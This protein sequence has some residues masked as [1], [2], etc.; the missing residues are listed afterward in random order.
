MRRLLKVDLATKINGILLGVISLL[1]ISLSSFYLYHYSQEYF[2]NAKGITLQSAKT[3]SYLPGIVSENALEDK[4]QLSIVMDQY[5]FDTDIDFIII[6]DIDGE[7]LYHP[8]SEEIGKIYDIKEESKA[9]IFGAYYVKENNIDI[10]ERAFI[11]YAPIYSGE[12]VREVVGVVKVGYYKSKIISEIYEKIIQLLIITFVFILISIFISR[13]FANYIKSE[14]LGYEPNEITNI[15]KNREN[16]FSALNEGIIS[17]DL[18]GKI[19][20]SNRAAKYFFDLPDID[21]IVYIDEFLNTDI[22]QNLES[23]KTTKKAEYLQATFKEKEFIVIIN[24]LYDRNE[25]NGYV[26]IIR[27]MTEK[28]E[29]TNKLQIVESLFDDLRAQSHEY[30]NKLHLISGLLELKQYHGIREVID[31]EMN[32]IDDYHKNIFEIEDDNIKA[33]LLAKINSAREKQVYIEI[34]E[35]SQMNEIISRRFLNSLLTIISNLLDNA[36]EAASNEKNKSVKVYFGYFDDWLEIMIQ[37]SGTKIINS[38]VIFKKGYSTKEHGI[39][40]GYGLYNVK[41]NV[42]LLNGFIDVF[43]TKE[44]TVF[45]VEIPI[46]RKDE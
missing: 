2:E 46:Y 22:N 7:V 32:N 21:S 23:A 14:T 20:Y 28:V 16:I 13:W 36:I 17:T 33:L 39:N 38:D 43:T 8:K 26:F 35:G 25:L 12:E 37:D 3:V 4:Q 29:L 11:A 44:K 40:K 42:D 18:N 41:R 5:I 24:N 10:D 1:I 19:E 45:T 15:L 31:E 6:Q 27:D 9:L 30:K 34:E